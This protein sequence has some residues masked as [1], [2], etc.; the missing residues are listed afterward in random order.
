MYFEVFT[1]NLRFLKEF[2]SESIQ[3]HVFLHF[4]IVM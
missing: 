3:K 4:K 1:W 2:D